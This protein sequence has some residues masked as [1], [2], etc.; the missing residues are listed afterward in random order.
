VIEMDGGP[1]QG[2]R[3]RIVFSDP[4]HLQVIEVTPEGKAMFFQK[5]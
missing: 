1:K 2:V 4:K 3:S 5:P